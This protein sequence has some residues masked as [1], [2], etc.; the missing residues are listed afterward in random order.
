M[1]LIKVVGSVEDGLFVVGGVSCFL[2]LSVGEE[3]L[4]TLEVPALK[5]SSYKGPKRRSNS[6][7]VGAVASAEGETFCSWGTGPE[8]S[9]SDARGGKTGGLNGHGLKRARAKTGTGQNGHRL[10][11]ALMG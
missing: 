2:E 3:E 4:L 8:L 9:Q 5:N 11:R 1:W 6:C 10:K 7:C